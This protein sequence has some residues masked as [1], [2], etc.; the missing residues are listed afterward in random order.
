MKRPIHFS[1]NFHPVGQG[2][3]ASGAVY[4]HHQPSWVFSWVYDCGSSSGKRFVERELQR[5]VDTN[6]PRKRI[7][8]LTLSHFDR[9]HISGVCDLLRQFAVDALLLPYMP[10]GQRLQ[11]AFEEGIDP[12]DALTGFFVNP[13][14]FL[15]AIQ[16]VEIRRILFVPPSGNEGPPPDEGEPTPEGPDQRK[17]GPDLDFET[18]KPD[19]P[20]EYNELAENTGTTSVEWLRSGARLALRSFWEFIPYND[21]AAAEAPL[22]WSN[23]VDHERA[24]L[25]AAKS[26]DARKE[27]LRRLAALYDSLF[28]RGSEQRNSISLFLYGGPI[29]PG[30]RAAILGPLS[31]PILK[32]IVDHPFLAYPG[33]PGKLSCSVLYTG[34]GYLDSRERLQRLVTF[35]SPSRIQKIGAFQVMHH[36]AASNWHHSVA[37][38]IRPKFSIFCSDPDHKRLGHPHASV[39]RDFWSFGPLQVDKER[40]IHVPG[41]L[42]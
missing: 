27:V 37:G 36:G 29:Y 22:A 4:E 2:L 10:L 40:F 17:D 11:I 24:E 12:D 18:G 13:V 20:R 3:F 6:A 15:L 5:L 1:Y 31:E 23:R 35:L 30:W 28:G 9:D 38:A 21:D 25:I 8:L 16:G 14:A 32:R 33:F 26:T 19:D 34:D 7:D 42:L 41:I 39:L